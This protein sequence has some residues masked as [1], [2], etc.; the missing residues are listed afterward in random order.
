MKTLILDLKAARQKK[1]LS[2]KD[3]GQKVNLPQSHIS[4]IE[5]GCTDLH[6]S[7]FIE[8]ARVLDL[9][10]FLIP[11]QLIPVVQSFLRSDQE[12]RPLWSVDLKDKDI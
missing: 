5:S 4:K 6:L 9:E 8:I 11:R 10:V 2:Q 7:T 1:K 12:E 3:L